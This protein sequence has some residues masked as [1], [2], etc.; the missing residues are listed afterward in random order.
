MIDIANLNVSEQERSERRAN[1]AG[2]FPAEV[3]LMV[4]EFRQRALDSRKRAV[5]FLIFILLALAVG[6]VTVAFV[7]MFVE[8]TVESARGVEQQSFLE[9]KRTTLES[10]RK[11]ETVL[12]GRRREIVSGMEKILKSGGTI[13]RQVK[14]GTDAN[15]Y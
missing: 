9:R 8:L 3:G 6:A 15:L 5:T 10:L 14:T 7:H 1:L 2:D 12:E 4:M 13:W 11:D